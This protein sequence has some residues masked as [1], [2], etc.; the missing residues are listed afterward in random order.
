MSSSAAEVLAAAAF[1]RALGIEIISLSLLS[2]NNPQTLENSQR[3]NNHSSEAS[4]RTVQMLIKEWDSCQQC[5]THT[6]EQQLPATWPHS[7]S[8]SQC[9]TRHFIIIIYLLNNSLTLYTYNNKCTTKGQDFARFT[10]SSSNSLAPAPS[11]WP[12]AFTI[13]ITTAAQ[14]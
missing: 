8:L 6:Q 5:N 1:K 2:L 10:N 4:N 12:P 14:W 13:I 11:A 3:D 7:Q 9:N